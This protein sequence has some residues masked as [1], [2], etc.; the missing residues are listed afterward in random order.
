MTAA[1]NNNQLTMTIE[2]SDGKYLNSL[3]GYESEFEPWL[4]EREHEAICVLTSRHLAL[5]ARSLRKLTLFK[6]QEGTMVVGCLVSFLFGIVAFAIAVIATCLHGTP[7]DAYVAAFCAI[8]AAGAAATAAL[9]WLLGRDKP[10]KQSRF[11]DFAKSICTVFGPRIEALWINAGPNKDEPAVQLTIHHRE[12]KEP[13][14]STVFG[15]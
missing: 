8:V 15:D 12:R 7:I 9:V 3:P 6:R 11:N 2:S 14:F 4:T 5:S 13:D 1:I 10:R